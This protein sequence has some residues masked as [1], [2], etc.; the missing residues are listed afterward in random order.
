MNFKGK[1]NPN[2][3]GG[4]SK[5]PDHL[6]FLNA[7][8]CIKNKEKIRVYDKLWHKTHK[9]YRKEYWQ[10]YYHEHPQLKNRQCERERKLY[11]NNRRR[12]RKM[13]AEGSHTL[14][15][16]KNLKKKYYYK[17]LHCGKKEPEI[18]LTEDHIIP[19]TK[20]GT[21]F[22]DNIQPLCRSCNS[23]KSNSIS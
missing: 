14:Q 13:N 3:K 4:I 5:D 18:K 11:L 8:W 12:A 17:C 9:D 16:W 6:K 20:D 2:W 7:R 22:I 19:L 10:R 1:N 23:H 21:D 15:D